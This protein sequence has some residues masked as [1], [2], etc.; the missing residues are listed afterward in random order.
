MVIYQLYSLLWDARDGDFE[1]SHD[2]TFS[3]PEAAMAY[4]PTELAEGEY[5]WRMYR[6]S[7]RRGYRRWIAL[8]GTRSDRYRDGWFS[9]FV[10]DECDVLS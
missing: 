9:A 6:C 8:Y 4:V 10:I 2:A 7:P 1:W 3:S 5:R